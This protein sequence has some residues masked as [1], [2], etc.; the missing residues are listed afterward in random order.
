MLIS[1][2]VSYCVGGTPLPNST[3]EAMLQKGYGKGLLVAEALHYLKISPDNWLPFSTIYRLLADNFN[4]SKRTVY[5][6]LQYRLVFQRRKAPGIAHRRGARPYLYRI[7]HPDELTAEF[8][9]HTKHT[10][11]DRLHKRYYRSLTT[12]RMGLHHAMYVRRWCSNGGRGFMMR[13]QADGRAS[14]SV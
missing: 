8:S 11:A 7:P 12:Y 14:R 13:P 2:K 1:S 10:P 9:P 6:G 4:T 3:R 5:E